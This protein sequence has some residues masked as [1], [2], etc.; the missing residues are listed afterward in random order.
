MMEYTMKYYLESH[1]WVELNGDVATVGISVHA[2]EELGDVTFVELPEVDADVNAGDS[3]SV[4]ES[5]KA[6]SDIYSP[7]GGTISEVNEDLE[8]EPEKINEDAHGKGWIFKVSG[9]NAS[10]VEKLMTE[11]QYAAFL[12]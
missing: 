5:V 10:A 1:E 12:K 3:V 8:D 11:E 6:A 9:V 4:V 2:A 7:V